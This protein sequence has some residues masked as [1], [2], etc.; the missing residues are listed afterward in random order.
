V[1][2]A[3]FNEKFDLFVPQTCTGC[4]QKNPWRI[5]DHLQVVGF[6]YDRS[7][8]CHPFGPD[9]VVRGARYRYIRLGETGPDHSV[10]VA[11][12]DAA[13]EKE[14]AFS[15][16]KEKAEGLRARVLRPADGSA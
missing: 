10:R 2:H 14:M 4:R 7:C 13:Y 12:A 8:F 1:P 5:E 3:F 11:E 16:D 15:G 9:N 6:S